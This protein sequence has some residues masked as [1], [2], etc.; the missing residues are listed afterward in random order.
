MP[1]SFRDSVERRS[2]VMLT[3][4]NSLPRVV[5]FA[6]VTG[7]LMAGLLTTGVLASVALAII[8]LFL[9]WLLYIGWPQ[10]NPIGRLLRLL[11]TL[12]IAAAAVEQLTGR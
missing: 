1:A 5:P 2:V 8:A 11:A 6:L 3:Y 7:L 12:L 9:A 10:M 4:L